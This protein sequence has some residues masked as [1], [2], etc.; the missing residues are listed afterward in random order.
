MEV[1]PDAARVIDGIINAY[2]GQ[3]ADRV[4]SYFAED[5]RVIGNLPHEDW[6]ASDGDLPTY[7]SGELNAFANL[8]WDFRGAKGLAP[9][10]VVV[11]T[12]AHQVLVMEGTLSGALHGQPFRHDG[13]WVCVLQRDNEEAGWKVRHSQFS[14]I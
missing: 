13:R 2:V 10:H 4:L 11:D 8:K 7:L 3:E 14:L 6:P 9:N 1:N 12:Q 5:A